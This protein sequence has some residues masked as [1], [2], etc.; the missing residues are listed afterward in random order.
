M[1]EEDTMKKERKHGRVRLNC[2]KCGVEFSTHSSNRNLC[3][4]CKPKCY[5]WHDFSD[6]LASRKNKG[7]KEVVVE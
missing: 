7:K 2:D 3:Y 4:K 5:E 1:K 6:F